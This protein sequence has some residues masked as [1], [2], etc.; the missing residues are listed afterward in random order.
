MFF[1]MLRWNFLAYRHYSFLLCRV[2]KYL[3]HKERA[4]WHTI[5]Y[6]YKVASIFNL[7][8]CLFVFS[9][10]IHTLSNLCL[11][12]YRLLLP[13]ISTFQKNIS[14]ISVCMRWYACIQM[15]SKKRC[16]FI[17]SVNFRHIFFVWH[18]SLSF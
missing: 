2:I 14:L 9:V 15:V 12:I 10:Q 16:V 1:L 6:A 13:L 7:F 11:C 5:K 18:N 17:N 3:R 8:I 4:Y